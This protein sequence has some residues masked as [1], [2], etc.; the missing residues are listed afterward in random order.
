MEYNRLGNS[1]LVVSELSFGSW[2]TFDYAKQSGGTV[3]GTTREQAAESCFEIMRAAYEGGVN[4]FDNAEAYAQGRAEVLMG[5]AV[6]MGILRRVWTREDLVLST[7]LM[8]GAMP[9]KSSPAYIPKAIPFNRTGLSRKHIVEGLKSSL[10]RMN[11]EYV[12]LVFCHRPDPVTPMEEIVRAMNHVID[13][14]YAFYWGTSEWSAAEL[15]SAKA[16]ADR[17]GLI[18]PLMDQTEYS[19]FHRQ[20][21]DVEYAYA[22]LFE[23]DFGLGLTVW[24]PLAS[25]ILTGKYGKGIPA[26]SRLASK[27]FQARPDFKIRFLDRIKHAEALRPIAKKL[28]CTMGQLSL[29]W[30]MK[31][32]NVSTVLT[33][34]TTVAQV[35]ENLKACAVKKMLNDEIMREIENAIGK[36]YQPRRSPT[37]RQ[38]ANYRLRK[39][40]KGALSKL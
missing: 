25:G 8:F 30:C 6:R 20:R 2:V 40:S 26:N 34:A 16:V 32:R 21:V 10:S 9:P 13:R 33:G 14:G 18:P 24:S 4:F 36:R 29:A 23:K 17:L 5:D 28:N 22:G 27:E 11:L 12:D 37:E 35:K 3:Q 15:M 7:K 19:L 38:V 39:F 31:N 1:G